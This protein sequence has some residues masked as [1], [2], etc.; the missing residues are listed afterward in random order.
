M[1]RSMKLIS[2]V[3]IRV[4]TKKNIRTNPMSDKQVRNLDGFLEMSS[5]EYVLALF[6]NCIQ[7]KT[8]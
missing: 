7:G 6:K 5:F 1:T 3:K 8:P 4:F 2:G